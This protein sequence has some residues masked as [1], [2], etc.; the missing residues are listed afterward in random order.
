MK[1]RILNGSHTSLVFPSLLCGV[2]TVG[3]SLKD[4]LLNAFLNTCLFDY[5]LPMLDDNEDNR[6]VC[7]SSAGALCKSVY[8]AFVEINFT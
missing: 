4:E 1:V 3:E 8:Q 2:E 6:Q 7:K 5:I